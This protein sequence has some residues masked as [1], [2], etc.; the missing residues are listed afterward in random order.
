M[1]ISIGKCKYVG[2]MEKCQ[3]TA[4]DHLQMYEKSSIMQIGSRV[5]VRYANIERET[6]IDG[7]V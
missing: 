3:M 5:G 6:L 4:L 7:R 2:N 1:R